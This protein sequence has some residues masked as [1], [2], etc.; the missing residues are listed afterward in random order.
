[1]EPRWQKLST[2][3]AKG[4]EK[5]IPATFPQNCKPRIDSAT[6]ELFD[7]RMAARLQG[8]GIL[9]KHLQKSLD[10]IAHDGWM[11]ELAFNGHW[12]SL[13]RLRQNMF[14]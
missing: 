12:H 5:A 13:R 8:H 6:P 10:A 14:A 7:P 1:M 2:S 4:I 11:S 9:E 3:M